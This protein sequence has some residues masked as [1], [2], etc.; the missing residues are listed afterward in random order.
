MAANGA[1]S[2]S[3]DRCAH[4]ARVGFKASAC[5]TP[6]SSTSSRRARSTEIAALLDEYGLGHLELE[7]LM[8]W[9]PTRPTSAVRR[10]IGPAT[11]LWEAAAALHA[12]H[13][14][15][16]NIPDTPCELPPA[17]RALRGA[18]RRRRRASR[19]RGSS[20]SSCRSTST[21]TTST[22]RS[23]SSTQRTPRTAGSRSTRGTS[24]SSHRPGELRALAAASRLGRAQRRP[25]REH[26][27][28]RRRDDQPP[29]IAGRGD[30]PIRA[31]VAAPDA[32]YDG[33]WG[34]E[35]LAEKLRSLPI[36]QIFDRAYETS[37]AALTAN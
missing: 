14:K 15:V 10:A 18:L 24:R 34:V 25:V 5:G 19:R 16:G 33:P 23:R 4:A 2:T 30:P 8:D 35:V 11:L 28:P 7:F 32:G 26:A 1:S 20:T 27:G 36:E 13:V 6:T 9:F 17:D 12:H 22:T 29:G 21:C 37:M 3:R 31:Y